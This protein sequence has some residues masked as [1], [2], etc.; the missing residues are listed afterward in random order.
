MA[1]TKCVGDVDILLW[2]TGFLFSF[3]L[4]PS[5]DLIMS[6]MTADFIRLKTVIC[7]TLA[8]LII[9]IGIILGVVYL[10]CDKSSL[11][12]GL[13]LGIGFILQ[14]AFVLCI[15]NIRTV[16]TDDPNI[17][18]HLWRSLLGHPDTSTAIYYFVAGL[19]FFCTTLYLASLN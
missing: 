15:I 10:D 7:C 2:L 6:L 8:G 17:F 12:L 13:G 18:E 9:I 1:E 11:S 16:F 4:K 14:A 3:A 19:F 5:A